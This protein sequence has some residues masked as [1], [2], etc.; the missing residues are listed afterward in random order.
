MNIY[1][2]ICMKVPGAQ[3]VFVGVEQG[4]YAGKCVFKG[5]PVI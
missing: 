3:L 5:F 1:P 4:R 2:Y